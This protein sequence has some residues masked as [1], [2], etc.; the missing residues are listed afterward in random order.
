MQ[1]DTMKSLISINLVIK[2]L[3]KIKLEN[4]RKLHE[5]KAML[6]Y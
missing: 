1:M 4:L 6:A 5:L 2:V 3:R